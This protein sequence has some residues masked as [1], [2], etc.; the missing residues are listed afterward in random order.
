MKKMYSLKVGQDIIPFEGIDINEDGSPVSESNI[1]KIFAYENSPTV[2]SLAGMRQIPSVGDVYD[3]TLEGFP[4]VRQ[5]PKS[6]AS[7]FSEYQNFA[8]VVNNVVKFV[9][10]ID[11]STEHGARFN[12]ALSSN[13]EFLEPEIIE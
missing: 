4:F 11:A 1:D 13:A 5:S 7:F 9:L 2:V 3:P 12:A 10:C 8:L 6:F